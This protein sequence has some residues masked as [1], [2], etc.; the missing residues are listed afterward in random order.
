MSLRTLKSRLTKLE[1]QR[2]EEAQRRLLAYLQRCEV[3][4]SAAER[5]DLAPYYRSFI[6]GHG[7]P[8]EPSPVVKDILAKLRADSEACR[9]LDKLIVFAPAACFWLEPFELPT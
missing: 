1:E 9:L 3:V 6:E 8:V 2:D 4:L 5:R 7:P